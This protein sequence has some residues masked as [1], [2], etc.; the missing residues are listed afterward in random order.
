MPLLFLNRKLSFVNIG[1]EF[2][3][4]GENSDFNDSK[5]EQHGQGI[6][7]MYNAKNYQRELRINGKADKQEER[8]KNKTKDIADDQ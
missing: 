1:W 6:V 7:V 8:Y 4:G 2:S 5:I 3:I